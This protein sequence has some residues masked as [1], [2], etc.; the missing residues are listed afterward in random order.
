MPWPI[1][2]TY[3]VSRQELAALLEETCWTFWEARTITE[4]TPPPLNIAVDQ[5]VQAALDSLFLRQNAP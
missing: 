3:T 1:D 4:Y 5:A 2:E